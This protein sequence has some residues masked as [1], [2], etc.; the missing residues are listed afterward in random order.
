MVMVKLVAEVYVLLLLGVGVLTS[1][2]KWQQCAEKYFDYFK[3]CFI[4]LLKTNSFTTA[5][6]LMMAT[7]TTPFC[8]IR[9]LSL[10]DAFKNKSQYFNPDAMDFNLRSTVFKGEEVCQCSV[11]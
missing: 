10:N 2:S 6:T 7:Q 9:I 8:L 4:P 1:E 11:P 5:D 3:N